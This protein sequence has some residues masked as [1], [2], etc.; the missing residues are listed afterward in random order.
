MHAYLQRASTA[1]HDAVDGMSDTQMLLHP[2]DKWCA[3]EIV[4]HL[5]LAYAGSAKLMSRCLSEGKPLATGQSL[6]QKVGTLLVSTFLFIPEGRKAPAHILPKGVDARTAV[7]QIF[8]NL[9]QLD[10]VLLQCESTFGSNIKIA[11]NPVLGALRADD[12]RKFHL[13][14]T[15]HHL[16]QIERIKQTGVGEGMAV[17]V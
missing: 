13:A 15:L 5:S 7:T 17:K 8:A 10:E 11:D 3:A 9:K 12:W 14:H 2:E 16:K 6:K 4:E 1:I